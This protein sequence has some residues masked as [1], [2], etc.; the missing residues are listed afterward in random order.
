[1]DVDIDNEWNID[2]LSDSEISQNSLSEP[3]FA[4]SGSIGATDFTGVLPN[5]EET[6]TENVR[7]LCMCSSP[8]KQMHLKHTDFFVGPPKSFFTMI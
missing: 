6:I 7:S 2:K 4:H 8:P 1:M 5:L 3:A